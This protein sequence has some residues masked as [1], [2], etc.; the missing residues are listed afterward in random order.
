MQKQIA[1]ELKLFYRRG[2]AIRAIPKLFVHAGNQSIPIRPLSITLKDRFHLV[3][4]SK[5]VARVLKLPILPLLVYHSSKQSL[6]VGPVVG[7]LVSNLR[8]TGKPI[9]FESRSYKELIKHGR[10]RG[11]LVYLFSQ[12]GISPD[13]KSIKGATIDHKG[14]W[15]RGVYP[16]PDIVYNRI[17]KRKIENRPE[18]QDLLKKYKEDP[19]LYLFNS[20]YLGKWEVYMAASTVPELSALFPLTLQFSRATLKFMLERYNQ[21]LIKPDTGSLGKGIIKVQRVPQRGFR[22]AASSAP[23]GWVSCKSIEDLYVA[24]QRRTI[25][26]GNFL[27]QE[28]VRLSRLNGRIFDVRA[29]FQKDG[30]GSWV[31]TG[32]VIRVAGKDQFVT[33]IPNGGRAASYWQVTRRVFRDPAV[34]KALDEQL[35]FICRYIPALLETHLDLNLG[36]VSMD[37]AID[38]RG[39]MWV[40]EVNSK[41]SSFDERNVRRR[42][43]R[44]LIDY[45]I[46]IAAER[47]TKLIEGPGL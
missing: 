37:I 38:Q 16:R 12:R 2:N 35:S 1:A 40:L 17:R 8:S 9:R 31:I 34:R 26:Q 4:P 14:Q 33:H 43:N 28:L 45:C 30:L 47:R 29:Q 36:I 18:I 5:G 20:R 7:V 32:V 15:V 11:V 27:I 21:V 19:R 24:L 44:L 13:G 10:Q 46:H 3:R 41:P 22:F 42:H 23:L 25:E 6:C 39:K